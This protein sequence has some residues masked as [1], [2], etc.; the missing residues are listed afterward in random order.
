MRRNQYKKTVLGLGPLEVVA[1]LIVLA[2]TIALAHLAGPHDSSWRD[3]I[4]A[5]WWRFL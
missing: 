2:F 3:L 1:I 4:P 5:E